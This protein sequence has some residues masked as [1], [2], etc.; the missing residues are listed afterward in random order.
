MESDAQLL[1]AWRDGDQNAGKA[2]VERHITAVCRFFQR[3]V[4]AAADDLTQA[5]F[6]ACQESASRLREA[7]SFRAF[8]FG[9]A[10][11]LLLRHLQGECRAPVDTT[12]GLQDMQTSASGRIERHSQ[13]VRLRRALGSLDLDDQLIIGMHYWDGLRLA[14]IAF[15]VEKP[16]G[17]IKWRLSEARRELRAELLRLRDAEPALFHSSEDGL[18]AWADALERPLSERADVE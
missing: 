6:L 2:L 1:L 15:V 16:V 13:R 7:E 5:T 12:S 3:R 4:G 10:R 8:L 14:E 18:D 11:N 9:V 17:T